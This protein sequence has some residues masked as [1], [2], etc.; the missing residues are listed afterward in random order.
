MGWQTVVSSTKSRVRLVQVKPVEREWPIWYRPWGIMFLL[1]DQLAFK[2]A[3]LMQSAC[4]PSPFRKQKPPKRGNKY[5]HKTVCHPLIQCARLFRTKARLLS[6]NAVWHHK[7]LHPLYRVIE[8]KQRERER[9]D[10][11]V[12]IKTFFFHPTSNRNVFCILSLT[13]KETILS[14]NYVCGKKEVKN[15]R[16][17]IYFK[18]GNFN[19]T[20][21]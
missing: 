15:A 3:L 8:F 6:C 5:K 13:S 14:H 16:L 11:L 17:E 19:Y 12:K 21:L 20:N 10:L 4:L 1:C 18:L 7:R 9:E 2:S